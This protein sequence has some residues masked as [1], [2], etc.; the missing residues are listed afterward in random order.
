MDDFIQSNLALPQPLPGLTFDSDGSLLQTPANVAAMGQDYFDRPSPNYP[1]PGQRPVQLGEHTD[2]SGNPQ[3]SADY[4]NYYGTWA[5]EQ[6]V[7]AEG[8]A[9]V[10]HQGA[11]PRIA[12]DSRASA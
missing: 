8:Q 11:R 2:L 4:T 9:N 12:I 7:G 6:I 1:Q 5:L 3:P 10:R